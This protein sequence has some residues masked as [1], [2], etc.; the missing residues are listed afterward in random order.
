VRFPFFGKENPDY[1]P[2]FDHNG[3]GSIALQKMIV[4]ESDGKIYLLPAW[5]KEWDANFKL[6]LR[7]NTTIEGTVK[8]GKLSSWQVYPSSRKK[9]VIVNKDF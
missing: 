9:D 5:P 4:Q 1:V 6:H 2:D 8:N 3:S 7:H